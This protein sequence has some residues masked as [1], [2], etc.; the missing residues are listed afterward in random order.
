MQN[1]NKKMLP[2]RR[3]NRF[4]RFGRRKRLTGRNLHHLLP[5]SRG[6]DDS[7][8]NL[9]LMKIEKHEAWHKLFGTM[10]A[11]EALALLQRVVRAKKKQA[12]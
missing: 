12:A 2:F 9:L 1:Y 6:G 7:I 5:R 4:R 11:E 8:S 10:S 3:P